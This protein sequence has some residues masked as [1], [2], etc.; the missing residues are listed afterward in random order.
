MNKIKNIISHNYFKA[1]LVLMIPILFWDSTPSGLS[2]EAYQTALVFLT[3]I[4]LIML[5]TLPTGAVAILSLTVYAALNVGGAKTPTLAIND[6]LSGFSSSLI[7]LIVIAVIVS[8]SFK[9]TG[10]GERLAIMLLA[11]RMGKSTIGVSYVLTFSDWLIAPVT[12]SNTARAGIISPLANS[13]AETINPK[14]KKL[15]RFFISAISA[16]NDIS[17]SAFTTAFLGNLVAVG[18]ILAST[19]IN[20]DFTMWVTYML[21]PALIVT[22]IMPIILFYYIK[23]E[24]KHSKEARKF[25]EESLHKMGSVS[26]NEIWLVVTL[27]VLLCLWVF[28]GVLGVNSTTAAFVGLSMLLITKVL[29]WDDVISEKPALDLLVWFGFLLSMATKLKTLGFSDYIGEKLSLFVDA[30][31]IGVNDYIILLVV[32]LAYLATSYFFASSTA[33]IMALAPVIILSMMNST[34][35]EPIII[36]MLLVAVSNYGGNLCCY[37]HARNPLM[38]QY[39]YHTVGEWMRIGAVISVSATLIFFAVAIP[40]WTLVLN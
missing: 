19:G 26:R 10:L 15:G 16:A 12:P 36:C 28:G 21:P 7:W 22:L 24:T 30:Y 31:S 34:N 8:K 17:A 3:T 9:V 14:D 39:G 23:P 37:S 18:I 32:M 4:V 2:I 35:I 38:M 27:V 25:A 5:N 20:V 11:T 33:K 40:Y 1:I 29:T 13:L 6:A